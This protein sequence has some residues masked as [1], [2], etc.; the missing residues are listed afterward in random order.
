[1]SRTGNYRI[2]GVRRWSD[3]VGTISRRVIE[4]ANSAKM[5]AASNGRYM[6]QFENNLR[7]I[8]VSN[9][10]GQTR[11]DFISW[12]VEAHDYVVSSANNG[13]DTLLASCLNVRGPPP[14]PAPSSAARPNVNIVE[15]GVG[16]VSINPT[17]VLLLIGI[18]CFFFR[19]LFK[20]L[21]F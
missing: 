8:G 10:E 16:I 19:V 2:E 13:I 14:P 3:Y 12:F 15:Q 21:R 5:L 7:G 1:M 17:H 4:A 6:T 11:D 18:V 20:R 9:I